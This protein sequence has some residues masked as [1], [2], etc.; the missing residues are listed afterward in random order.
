MADKEQTIKDQIAAME[1]WAIQAKKQ[2]DALKYYEVMKLFKLI[3][4]QGRRLEWRGLKQLP[5]MEES[6][7]LKLKISQGQV[8]RGQISQGQISRPQR[9]MATLSGLSDLIP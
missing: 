9:L 4:V 5:K 1:G 6:K 3:N 7:M 2:M 8:S